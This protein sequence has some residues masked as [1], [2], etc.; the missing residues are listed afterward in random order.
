MPDAHPGSFLSVLSPAALTAGHSCR[1]ASQ[2]D[3][4]AAFDAVTS[5][6]DLETQFVNQYTR[7]SVWKH[8]YRD[9]EVHFLHSFVYK[10]VSTERQY[11]GKAG[12][13]A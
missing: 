1:R 4:A 13:N 11:A 9:G 8:Q 7:K 10:R 12:R 3:R 5:S 6:V 2:R